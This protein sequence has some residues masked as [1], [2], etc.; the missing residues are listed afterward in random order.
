MANAKRDKLQDDLDEME[1]ELKNYT[2][3]AEDIIK[4]KIL[5]IKILES[6]LFAYEKDGVDGLYYSLNRKANEMSRLLNNTA[7]D[8]IDISDP[9]DKTFERIQSAWSDAQN[10]AKAVLA[11]KSMVNIPVS[12]S[13]KDTKEEIKEVPK[14]AY[15]AEMVADEIGELAGKKDE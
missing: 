1:A 12:E 4:D 3:T 7:L 14:I 15:T 6:K 9:K 13:E 5:Q 2:P 10:L 8:T 11:L